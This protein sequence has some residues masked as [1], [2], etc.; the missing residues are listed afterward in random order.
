VQ[1]RPESLRF[2]LLAFLEPKQFPICNAS[3]KRGVFLFEQHFYFYSLLALYH[4]YFFRVAKHGRQQAILLE[5]WSF[6]DLPGFSAW[7]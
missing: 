1:K 4:Y 7:R 3:H 5:L 2:I 6:A